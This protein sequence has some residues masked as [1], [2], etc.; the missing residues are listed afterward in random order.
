MYTYIHTYITI[1]DNI[2]SSS[3]AP[4]RRY[5]SDSYAI[6]SQTDKC[7]GSKSAGSSAK[8]P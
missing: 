8:G 1:N 5:L 4:K 6:P 3:A 7:T 2:N